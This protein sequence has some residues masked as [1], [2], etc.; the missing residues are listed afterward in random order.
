MANGKGFAG[1]VMIGCG[2]LIALLFGACSVFFVFSILDQFQSNGWISWDVIGPSL[3]LGFGPFA[4]GVL[5][6]VLGIRM[7]RK[8]D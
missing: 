8:R 6:I 3:M 1:G 5:M 4:L 2:L 7:L